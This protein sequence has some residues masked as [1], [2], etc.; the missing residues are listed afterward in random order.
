MKTIKM[1]MTWADAVEIYM[2]ALENGTDKGKDAARAEFRRMAK[3]L[4]EAK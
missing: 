4:D 2:M 3:M 1:Q